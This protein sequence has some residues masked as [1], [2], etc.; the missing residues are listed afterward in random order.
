MLPR[1]QLKRVK[2]ENEQLRTYSGYLQKQHMFM[3]TEANH[4]RTKC[5]GLEEEVSTL[6]QQLQQVVAIAAA[7]NPGILDAVA[8]PAAPQ[9]SH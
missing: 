9:A 7:V 2:S 5:T 3:S 6:F 1:L 8:P 4:W